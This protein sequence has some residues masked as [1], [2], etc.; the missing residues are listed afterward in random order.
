MHLSTEHGKLSQQWLFALGGGAGSTIG[1]RDTVTSFQRDATHRYAWR[2]TCLRA[3]DSVPHTTHA[4]RLL[5]MQAIEA[6][7]ALL[8]EGMQLLRSTVNLERNFDSVPVLDLQQLQA[9]RRSAENALEAVRR[10][11]CGRL[12][13]TH[14]CK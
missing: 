14:A 11:R 3:S 6:S 9:A 10:L 2:V 1:W 4:C 13:T 7:A 12:V 8:A 5:A